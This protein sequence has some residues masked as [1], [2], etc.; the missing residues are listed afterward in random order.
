MPNITCFSGLHVIGSEVSGSCDDHGFY[1]AHLTRQ[2]IPVIGY[3][4]LARHILAA[5]CP[6]CNE[7]FLIPP[8]SV[9]SM[10][11]ATSDFSNTGI[12]IRTRIPYSARDALD[13]ACW[14]KSAMESPALRAPL[15]DAAIGDLEKIHGSN[16]IGNAIQRI[17]TDATSY[18]GDGVLQQDAGM[19]SFWMS[20]NSAEAIR[21][22]SRSFRFSIGTVVTAL[23]FHALTMSNESLAS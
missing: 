17:V 18:I 23:C 22:Y 13:L 21:D 7:D 9:P 15:I 6:N 10:R 1:R 16:E 19:Q 5:A 11:Y 2:N 12:E 14:R 8:Q 20:E 4:R 3:R